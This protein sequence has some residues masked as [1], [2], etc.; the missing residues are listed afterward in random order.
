MYGFYS[1]CKLIFINLIIFTDEK[2]LFLAMPFANNGNLRNY[3][4]KNKL[5]FGEKLEI[6]KGIANGIKVL[7]NN[8]VVHANIVSNTI[9]LV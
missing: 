4:K 2:N 9:Y 7:H 5:A 3:I 1:F 6:A 8:G